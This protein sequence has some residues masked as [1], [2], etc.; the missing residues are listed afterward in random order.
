MK[1][2]LIFCLLI[3]PGMLLAQQTFEGHIAGPDGQP[4]SGVT[5]AAKGT[6]SGTLTDNKGAFSL[7]LNPGATAEAIVVRKNKDSKAYEIEMSDFVSANSY[8]IYI[9]L[10]DKKRKRSHVVVAKF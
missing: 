8:G 4:L 7:K 1:N 2:I 10:A 5:V 6:N 9:T 3:L